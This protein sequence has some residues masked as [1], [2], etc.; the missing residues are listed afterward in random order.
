MPSNYCDADAP[1]YD[2]QISTD[3]LTY[4]GDDQSTGVISFVRKK[5]CARYIVRRARYGK[6]HILNNMVRTIINMVVGSCNFSK[7]VPSIK[8]VLSS[9]I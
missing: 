3:L 4:S 9:I 5:G 1:Q 2:Y 7:Q 8:C 6:H